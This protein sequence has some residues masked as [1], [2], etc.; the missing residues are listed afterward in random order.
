MS[1]ERGSDEEQG[2]GGDQ[3]GGV[4][5]DAGT[6]RFHVYIVDVPGGWCKHLVRCSPM[7][8]TE[9]E[10]PADD[11]PE[12]DPPEP[13]PVPPMDEVDI[14]GLKGDELWAVLRPI[15]EQHPTAVI[16]FRGAIEDDPNGRSIVTEE[17]QQRQGMPVATAVSMHD[18]QPGSAEPEPSSADS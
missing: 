18:N 4:E 7:S 3:E 17:P 13:E 11:A 15:A 2:G 16:E 8:D 9:P 12:T 5:C 14:T 6:N 10:I 1:E